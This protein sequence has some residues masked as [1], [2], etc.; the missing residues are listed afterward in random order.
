MFSFLGE[1]IFFFFTFQGLKLN[2]TKKGRNGV[3]PTCCPQTTLSSLTHGPES[4]STLSPFH[5]V[6]TVVLVMHCSVLLKWKETHVG[7]AIM[8]AQDT[9]CES[10]S[11]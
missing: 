10:E 5:A 2:E 8:A 1:N 6:D 9:F 3:F 4:S 11:P 7:Q